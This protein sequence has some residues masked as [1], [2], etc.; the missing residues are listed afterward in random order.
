M[1]DPAA[2][3]SA[4]ASRRAELTGCGRIAP[5]AAQL[6]EPADPGQVAGLLVAPPVAG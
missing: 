5:P 1:A 2:G 4:P 6:A 3:A